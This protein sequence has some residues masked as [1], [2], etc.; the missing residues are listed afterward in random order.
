M[1]KPDSRNEP[2]TVRIGGCTVTCG[3]R[4]LYRAASACQGERMQGGAGRAPEV[5]GRDSELMVLRGLVAADRRVG[6]LL[7]AGAAGIGKTA[8]WEAGLEMARAAGR[9]VLAARPAGAEAGMAF[10]GLIDLCDRV[11]PEVLACLPAPQRSALEV[12]LLRAEPVQGAAPGPQAIALAF[13]NV[14]RSMAAD[15]P[16]VVA[17]DDLPWLDPLSMSS[18]TFAA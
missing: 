15:Q 10:A 4:S 9:F 2:P 13:L 16:L 8:L 12:A 1:L 14:L 6:A 17:V 18:L 5:F 11:G 7:L 3:D